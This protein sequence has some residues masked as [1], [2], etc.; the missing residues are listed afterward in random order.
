MDVSE[1]ESGKEGWVIRKQPEGVVATALCA[2]VRACVRTR[3]PPSSQH[4]RRFRATSRSSEQTA[5]RPR[6]GAETPVEKTDGRSPWAGDF[7]IGAAGIRQS[8]PGSIAKQP[9]LRASLTTT[10]R[11]T[12][13]QLPCRG[14]RSRE[15]SLIDCP[16]LASA[17][18][19]VSLASAR[20]TPPPPL[21]PRAPPP[22]PLQTSSLLCVAFWRADA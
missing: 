7:G 20:E 5:G 6:A 13:I 14:P 11:Y 21:A 3:R 19:A 2:C 12:A 22:T 16:P 18:V 8:S 10:T 9:P 15:E 17:A 1:E 4:S